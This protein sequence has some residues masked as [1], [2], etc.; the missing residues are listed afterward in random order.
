M[1]TFYGEFDKKT[2]ILASRHVL[3]YTANTVNKNV[4]AH[5]ILMLRHPDT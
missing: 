2:P 3:G 5:A 4:Y 1:K